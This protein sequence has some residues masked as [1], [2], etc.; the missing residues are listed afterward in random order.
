MV[1]GALWPAKSLQRNG[2]TM[3]FWGGT[4]ALL[5]VLPGC[6]P[7]KRR[8]KYSPGTTTSLYVAQSPAVLRRLDILGH[9]SHSHKVPSNTTTEKGEGRQEMRRLSAFNYEIPTET[10]PLLL[11]DQS[12]SYFVFLVSSTFL[13]MS[14][15]LRPFSFA[16]SCLGGPS[17]LPKLHRTTLSH[18]CT[19]FQC[20]TSQM[21]NITCYKGLWSR[22]HHINIPGTLVFK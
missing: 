19:R 5:Q 10:K 9:G 1:F 21:F 2:I 12:W 18:K 13:H 15:P 17:G 6:F 20:G 8:E 16:G 3:V 22:T 14:V 11:K 4:T 7:S